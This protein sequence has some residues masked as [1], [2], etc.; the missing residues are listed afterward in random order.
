MKDY[1]KKAIFYTLGF[2]LIVTLAFFFYALVTG[3]KTTY[4]PIMLEPLSLQ[5][6][7]QEYIYSLPK[8]IFAIIIMFFTI[9]AAL[10]NKYLKNK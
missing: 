1:N 8:F 2:F 7:F 4:L 3:L 10:K 9:R 6:A 5:E